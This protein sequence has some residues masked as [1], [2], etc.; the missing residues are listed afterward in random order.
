MRE[1]CEKK[2]S[3]S[4]FAKML[5][6]TWISV[7]LYS[8]FLWV[9]AL[10]LNG[11]VQYGNFLFR[12]RASYDW[13]LEHWQLFLGSSF[14]IAIVMLF[15]FCLLRNTGLAIVIPGGIITLLGYTNY[16]AL[17]TRG[18]WSP[19]HFGDL[20]L[21]SQAGTMAML[22]TRRQLGIYLFIVVTYLLLIGAC[23]LFAPRF[24]ITLK[25]RTL[26]GFSCFI[27]LYITYSYSVDF[28]Q[29]QRMILIFTGGAIFLCLLLFLCKRMERRLL[30]MSVGICMGLLA[31]VLLL[32]Q[33]PVRQFVA[34]RSPYPDGHWSSYNYI[35]NGFTFA[36]IRSMSPKSLMSTPENFSLEAVEAIVVEYTT[37][38]RL[39]NEERECFSNVKPNIIL[40]MSEAFYDPAV[41][42]ETFSFNRDPIPHTRYIMQ[43]NLSGSA[44]VNVYGGA[45]IVPEFQA[46]TGFYTLWFDSGNVHFYD[47]ILWHDSFPSIA[48]FFNSVGY[49]STAIHSYGRS[50]YRRYMGFDVLGFA[51]F[52]AEDTMTYTYL[53]GLWIA[54]SAAFKEVIDVIDDQSGQFVFLI[55]MQNHLPYPADLHPGIDIYASGDF[56][57]EILARIETHA[58]G[59]YISD[60][61]FYVF[62][63]ELQRQEETTIVLFF[64]DHL[65]A[66]IPY[67]FFDNHENIREQ[68]ETPLF[69]YSNHLSVEMGELGSVSPIFFSYLLL[70]SMNMQL[71]PFHVLLGE[72]FHYVQGMHGEWFIDSSNVKREK[73]EWNESIQSLV[74]QLMFIQYDIISGSKISY[75]EGFFEIP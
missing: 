25:V 60:Q 58:R 7:T 61:A 4:R 19:L 5:E 34:A 50:F 42:S 38:A 48:G 56:D 40:I 9:S 69:I 21:I 24:N 55:T 70:E 74:D 2:V 41:F 33:N 72:L 44:L 3:F 57:Y 37:K 8:A 47:Y 43:N 35:V 51:D 1:K 32:N 68:F 71:S 27:F 54:D 22:I 39:L 73:A 26:L 52:I 18:S 20:R 11:F 6:P 17:S 67:A 23:L 31:V 53:E 46:L 30:G 63:N 66:A 28:R 10:G 29:T 45:T 75:A 36:F 15:F 59:M 12:R 13:L 62:L 16:L 49:T 64:G 65:P 14:I